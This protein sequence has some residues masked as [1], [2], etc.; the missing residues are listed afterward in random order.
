MYDQLSIKELVNIFIE[1]KTNLSVILSKQSN[2]VTISD[3]MSL[4]L[5]CDGQLY[6]LY[7]IITS[8]LITEGLWP[9]DVYESCIQSYN[10]FG[11]SISS[12]IFNITSETGY[13]FV[14]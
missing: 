12:K 1:K 3:W 2:G 10:K 11:W 13:F 7:Q 6:L 9:G 14:Y 5:V 4:V 8:S